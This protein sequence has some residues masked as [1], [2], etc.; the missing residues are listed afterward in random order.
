MVLAW[1][2]KVLP[3]RIAITILAPAEMPGASGVGEP[4]GSDQRQKYV[5]LF[6]VNIASQYKNNTNERL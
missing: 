4:D 5:T 6:A 1:R 2:M 3:R